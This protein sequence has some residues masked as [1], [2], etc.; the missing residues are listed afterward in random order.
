M[1]N[2]CIAP[3]SC[4]H[5]VDYA[6]RKCQEGKQDIV[7]IFKTLIYFVEFCIIFFSSSW[8]SVTIS[9]THVITEHEN[10]SSYFFVLACMLNFVGQHHTN[11]IFY[12]SINNNGYFHGIYVL[13]KHTISLTNFTSF[14]Q[15]VGEMSNFHMYK[16]P[17]NNLYSYNMI[18]DIHYDK[19]KNSKAFCY[20]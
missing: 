1:N 5:R 20:W 13:C 3:W 7:V 18:A 19:Y 10:K 2:I 8:Q 9:N 15:F 11:W 16:F 6:T 12:T 17:Q 4:L 14:F